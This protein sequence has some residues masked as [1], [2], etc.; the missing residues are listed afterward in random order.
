MDDLGAPLVG[1]SAHTEPRIFGSCSLSPGE[2]PEVGW[3]GAIHTQEMLFT[4][5]PILPDHE[6]KRTESG[7]NQLD[8][9]CVIWI[10]S[11]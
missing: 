1:F 5:S 10:E 4:Y 3:A 2:T 6:V 8:S 9:N 11:E 7:T